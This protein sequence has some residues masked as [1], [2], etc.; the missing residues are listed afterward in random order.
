MRQRQFRSFALQNKLL[1][2]QGHPQ[3]VC[4]TP[5]AERTGEKAREKDE[6]KASRLLEYG[7]GK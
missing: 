4:R 5:R 6:K 1:F 7:Y 3:P 2:N